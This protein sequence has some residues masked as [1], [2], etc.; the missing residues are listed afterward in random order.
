MTIIEPSRSTDVTPA[1][2]TTSRVDPKKVRDLYDEGTRAIRAEQLQYQINSA[3]VQGSQW[4]YVDRNRNQVTDLPRQ[5]VDRAR[6]TMPRLRGESRAIVAKVVQRPLVFEVPPDASDDSHVKAARVAEGVLSDVVRTHDWELLRQEATWMCWKG[7]TAL[8]ALDW[9]AQAGVELGI[10]PVTYRP[11]S[12][13]DIKS[14]CLS[15]AEVATEPGTRDIRYANWW[16]KAVALPPEEVKRTYGLKEDPAKDAN[17]ASSPMQAKI[18]STNNRAGSSLDLT[19]V[20]TYYERPNPKNKTGSVGVIVGDK[21]VEGPHPWPFPFTDRL[22]ISCARETIVETR[23]TGDTI[24]SDAVPIQTALNAAWSSIT[25][26]M[27]LAGNARLMI[28]E[29]SQDLVEN[30]TDEAGEMQLYR[31]KPPA[32]LTPPTMPDWWQRMPDTLNAQMD[33][34]LGRHD[35]SRGQAP[36]NIES[37]L[38]IQILVEQDETPTGHLSRVMADLFGDFATLVL[39][40]YEAKAIEPR[41]ATV[42]L[43]GAPAQKMEWTGESFRGQT[44]TR[45]PYAAVAPMN[46]AA[47]FARAVTLKQIEVIK[48]DTDFAAYVDMPGEKS[49][50]EDINWHLAKARRENQSMAVGEVMIPAEFDDHSMHID[51]HNRYR[52][53]SDYEHLPSEARNLVDLHVQAHSTL[54]AEEAAA[55]MLKMQYGPGLAE[56]AQVGQPPGSA[57]PGMMPGEPPG[58]ANNMQRPGGIVNPGEGEPA[59]EAPG[60]PAAP[61]PPFA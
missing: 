27:K 41:E 1:N 28:E 18:R 52:S 34:V 38:G 53:T 43:P 50:M 47:K 45:V 49:F 13:G 33:D 12:V 59:P 31:D 36:A 23:W 8:L 3:F 56:A 20:L 15:I 21:W 37:G 44:Y 24:L 9:D 55:Q 22:N 35:V 51:Q 2:E 16:I 32:Y 14:S 30:Y 5:N 19:L 26:H 7:G 4:V 54:A 46:E 60:S 39:K 6:I 61:T 40:T 25:E 58:I 57:I 42:R 10:D 29:A 11:F 17:A 48:N